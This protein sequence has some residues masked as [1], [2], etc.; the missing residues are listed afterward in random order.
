M[1]EF[2]AATAVRRTGEATYEGETAPGWD[3]AGNANG[4]E[5]PVA[6]APTLELTAHIRERPAAGPL[7]VQFS[8]RF[9]QNG[10]FEE[11]GEVWDGRGVLVAQSRQ[12]AL[13]PKQ[14]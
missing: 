9:I 1:G 12:L 4:G 5:F 13:I 7:M 14:P 10:M 6:W 11:D 2:E 3:I 8:S